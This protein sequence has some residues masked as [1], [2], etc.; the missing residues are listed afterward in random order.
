MRVLAIL[1]LFQYCHNNN[2]E[3]SSKYRMFKFFVAIFPFYHI[4]YL[5]K[6]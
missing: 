5:I 3:F 6:D 1:E 2:S 4:G